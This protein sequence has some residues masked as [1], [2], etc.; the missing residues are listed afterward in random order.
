[1]V[2]IEEG[3]SGLEGREQKVG[4]SERYLFMVGLPWWLRQ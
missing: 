2:A 4:L 3:E 1:M